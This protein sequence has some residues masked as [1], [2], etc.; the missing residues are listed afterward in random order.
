MNRFRNARFIK[1]VYRAEELEETVAEIAFI[2]RSNVGKSSVINKICEKKELARTSKTPGR[3]RTI[4]IVLVGKNKWIVDLPGYGFAAGPKTDWAKMEKMIEGYLLNRPT[5]RKI[6][7]LV[8]AEVGATKLDEEMTAWL[9]KN[10]L[11]FLIVANKCDKISSSKQQ[12]YRKNVAEKLGRLPE[13]I[14]WVSAEKGFGMN[15]L[16]NEIADILELT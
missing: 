6:I 1:S 14:R 7:V 8:D 12:T 3:T 16:T 10:N 9:E 5:L 15:A 4:N 13:N 2:G 11:P